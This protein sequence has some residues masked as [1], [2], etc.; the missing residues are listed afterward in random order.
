MLGSNR[1]K[2]VMWMT[3]KVIPGTVFFAYFLV[4]VNNELR[5]L[6]YML[7]LQFYS[8]GDISYSVCPWFLIFRNLQI[9]PNFIDAYLLETHQCHP[10]IH[11]TLIFHQTISSFQKVPVS[12][13]T[14][15]IFILDTIFPFSIDGKPQKINN[16]DKIII[17]QFK[18]NG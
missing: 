3:W 5:K 16:L 4:F 11:H 12:I 9:L 6:P 1:R 10:V 17:L 8:S 14:L 7:S 13:F 15:L 18:S 2:Q